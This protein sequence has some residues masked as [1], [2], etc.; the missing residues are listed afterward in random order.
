MIFLLLFLL[1]AA[2]ARKQ[3]VSVWPDVTIKT[4]GEIWPLPQ[5]FE[6]TNKTW[7]LD[8]NNLVITEST[9]CEII[10]EAIKRYREIFC[11]HLNIADDD[12][13]TVS[14]ALF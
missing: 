8:P 12:P 9:H 3:Y 1:G 2:E 14:F 6:K 4:K 13:Q 11:K 7:R 10:T 5:F